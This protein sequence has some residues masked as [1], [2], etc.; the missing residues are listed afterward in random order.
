MSTVSVTKPASS[1]NLSEYPIDRDSAE[2]QALIKRCQDGLRDVGC[3]VLPNF[4]SKTAQAQI[5]AETCA[6]MKGARLYSRYRSSYQSRSGDQQYPLHH[7]RNILHL[8]R[9]QVMRQSEITEKAGLVQLY[10]SEDL[11]KFLSDV[12]GRP[13]QRVELGDQS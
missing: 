8:D 4:V 9:Y 5:A 2:R 7:P 11:R 1:I 10:L 6:S 3:F 13:Q 12:L